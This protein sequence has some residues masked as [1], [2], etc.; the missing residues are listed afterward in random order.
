MILYHLNSGR[1][2][3][4]GILTAAGLLFYAFGSLQGLLMLILFALINFTCGILIQRRKAPRL[5]A[6]AAITF[7][8][9]F[10]C[11]FK[12]LHFF[13][14]DTLLQWQAAVPLGISFFT[15]KAISYIADTLRKPEN[16]TQN[17]GTFLLYL[18]FLPEAACGPI[19]RFS[20]FESQ[21]LKERICRTPEGLRRFTAGLSK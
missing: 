16:G 8:L 14:E 19:S 5:T 20:D 13:P 6:A 2:W 11:F 4:N 7:N 9:L 15:F 12:Y 21:L 3:R 18:S 17:F 10:L 1:R